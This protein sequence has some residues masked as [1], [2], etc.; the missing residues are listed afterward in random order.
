MFKFFKKSK[1]REFYQRMEKC[2][3]AWSYL[4]KNNPFES[5]ISVY[6]KNKNILQE[7]ESWVI[8]NLENI[9]KFLDNAQLQEVRKAFGF[10][11]TPDWVK[12]EQK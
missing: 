10:P 1:K 5:T 4:S 9:K 11:Y 3:K 12:E 7:N 8:D 2:S 6:S